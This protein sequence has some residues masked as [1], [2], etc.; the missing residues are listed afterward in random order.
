MRNYLKK[1]LYQNSNSLLNGF[2]LILLS[3]KIL[4]ILEYIIFNPN[5]T[6][7]QSGL[8]YFTLFNEN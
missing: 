3:F 8:E 1:N 2:H 4:Y 6:W 5:F 7:F